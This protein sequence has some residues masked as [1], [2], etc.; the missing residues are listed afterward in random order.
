QPRVRLQAAQREQHVAAQETG[1]AR[2]QEAR[3]LSVQWTEALRSVPSA[4]PGE[5]AS[6]TSLGVLLPSARRN[7]SPSNTSTPVS[8][9]SSS[10]SSTS[11]R[12]EPG[13]RRTT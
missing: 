8:A 6:A 4:A 5:P 11:R 7:L 2:D 13:R 10:A 1:A 9:S 3:P 12:N